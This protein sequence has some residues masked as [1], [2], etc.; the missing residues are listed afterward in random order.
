MRLTTDGSLK[1]KGIC[2]AQEHDTFFCKEIGE[3]SFRIA[4]RDV[5]RC[6]FFCL[7]HTA[8]TMLLVCGEPPTEADVKELMNTI[9]KWETTLPKQ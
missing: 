7:L 5:N 1:N 2:E 8:R 6:G 3:F 4:S 9:R